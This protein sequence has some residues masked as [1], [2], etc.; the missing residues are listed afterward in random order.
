MY[1][2]ELL[3]CER[4]IGLKYLRVEDVRDSGWDIDLFPQT[5]DWK[6]TCVLLAMQ[7]ETAFAVIANLV[8]LC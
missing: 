6:P 2:T 1:Y 5:S 4:I 3:R 8:N 7:S